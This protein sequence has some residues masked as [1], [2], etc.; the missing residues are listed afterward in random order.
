MAWGH[1]CAGHASGV[2]VKV[3]PLHAPMLCARVKALT[4]CGQAVVFRTLLSR[5][6]YRWLIVCECLLLTS[7]TYSCLAQLS[8]LAVHAAIGHRLNA[9]G[10]LPMSKYRTRSG[11][12]FVL[13][14]L[15]VN[16]T[17][18]ASVLLCG[19]VPTV[20]VATSSRSVANCRLS[21]MLLLQL[22]L[23]PVCVY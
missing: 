20:A 4:C 22:S 23:R 2:H 12:P 17:V 1:V 15:R 13:F 9:D 19:L 21:V 10:L 18:L 3:R 16:S 11:Y 8:E 6:A 14:D 5:Q 7:G